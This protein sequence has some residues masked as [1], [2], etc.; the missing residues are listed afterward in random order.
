M[1]QDQLLSLKTVVCRDPELVV[2]E[3]NEA[4]I[5]LSIR[6][7]KYYGFEAVGSR[8][9]QLIEQPMTIEAVCD[10]LEA[11]FDVDR[12]VCEAETLAFIQQLLDESLVTVH[13]EAN[14]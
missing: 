7:E 11:E 9:W 3:L 14:V 6:N 2:S 10:A 8:I 4:T 13:A 1:A 12:E 5:M